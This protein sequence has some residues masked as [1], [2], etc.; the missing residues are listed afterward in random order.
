MRFLRRSLIGIFLLSVT[1]ALFAWAGNTVRGAV[2]ARMNAEPRSFPQRERVFA[3]N[4]VRVEPQ[5]IAPTLT[6]FGELRSQRSLALRSAIGGTVIEASNALV[7]GGVVEAGDLLLRLDPADAQAA[8]DRSAADV[9]DAEA[10]LRDAERA[11]K[12]AQDELTAAEQQAALRDQAL[13]RTRDL[14]TRG[15]G[16]TASVENAELAASTAQASVLASRQSLAN[17]EARIDQARTGV[18]RAQ[19]NLTEAQRDL[20][21]TAIYALFDGVLSDVNVTIGGRVSPNEQ[22]ATLLDP[23]DLEVSFR[24]STTQYARLIDENGT[25]PALPITVSLDVSGVNLEATGVISRESGAVGDSQSGRLLFATLE[26]ARGF[27]P[28]DFVTVRVQ[29]PELQRVAMVPAT[30]VAADKTVLVVGEENRLRSVETAILRR[31]GDD[32]IIEVR[33]LAGELIVAERSPLLGEGIGINPIQSGV[34]PEEPEVVTLDEE[35]RAK[36]VAF[37]EGSRMPDEAKARV[38]SQLEQDEVPAETIA[39]LESRMDS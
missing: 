39:R 28:G 37:V 19:I 5:T 22:F 11:V 32:V 26:N 21:E 7:E 18:A 13:A 38:I 6:T 16:T 15:V 33:E 27:R 8:A 36:L 1:V 3:A 25:L 2:E 34:A 23:R 24:I 31:Q 10:E 29:E 17:A 12:L 20:D 35:R 9:Q 14:E 30:A 4:V